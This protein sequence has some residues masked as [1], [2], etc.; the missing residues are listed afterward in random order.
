MARVHFLKTDHLLLAEVWSGN[1][2]AELRRD[3]R[4]FEVGDELVLRE[5]IIGPDEHR[6]YGAR[7]A[8]VVVT[9][10]LRDYEGLASGFAILSFQ[11]REKCLGIPRSVLPGDVVVGP[12]G[13]G[14]PSA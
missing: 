13:E 5:Y 12:R 3:D 4:G 7:C 9:H 6:G 11:L 8:L 1:K 10:I 14:H 2:T